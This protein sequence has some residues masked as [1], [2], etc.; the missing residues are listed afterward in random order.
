MCVS[1]V[2]FI[3]LIQKLYKMS[4]SEIAILILVFLTFLWSLIRLINA[5]SRQSRKL[6]PG[7]TALPIIGNLH[8]LGDLPHRSLQNLAKKYGPIMSMRLGFIPT[9]VVSSPKTAELF[10]K[11]HDT[12]F[13][14]RPKL[15]ASEYMA[16]GTKAMALT[17]YGPYWRRIRKLCTL[18][19]LC[20]SKIEGFAP[21]RR[22]EVGLLVQSLKVAAEAGEVVDFSEKVGELVE[23]ITYRMVLGRKNDDMFDLK[24]IIEEALFL[25][26]AFNISD[27][28][29]F[30][31]PLDL[32]GLT[33]RMKRVSKTVDQLLEKIIQDHE[34]VSR[35]EVQ[36]NH[37]KDFVDVL[38]SSIHQP[39]NPNDEEVYMLERTNVKAILLDMIAGAFDTSATAIVWTLAELLRHPKVMKRLQ[40]ELQSV[41]GMDRMVEES[42]LPKLDYLSMVVKESLRLHPV[43]PLLVPHQSM[44]DIT[45]DG[46]HIP[47]KS[48][49]FIN[50][51]T[52]GRDPS[53]WSDNVEEFYPERFMNNNVDLRGHD[54]QL[55]PFGSGRRGCPA[56]QLGLTTVR[57]VLGNLLHCF[58]WELP[59]GML[60]K[61]LDM[62]EKFGLSLS[63]AKHLL[64]MPTCRLYNGS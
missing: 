4:P 11:T 57:L 29:P 45:V 62:T 44:E 51:W 40:E 50:I 37:H 16:Y 25:T 39:L 22:E 55:I 48:R 10:L 56:M 34:Q 26:G 7:P 41:I 5:S 30:L 14:S 2:P 23:G 53:V 49:V 6:P 17:E 33:K 52:I 46:Y 59:S 27:Y 58:N 36:G 3:D 21:L 32:Q 20:P 18:Q 12:I 15:Q 47:K 35:S 38:L 64:A 63:K 9:I 61:D 43:A 19:L 24:G 28:V 54:F 60:P 13:A 1:N 42:D 31:S 8:M